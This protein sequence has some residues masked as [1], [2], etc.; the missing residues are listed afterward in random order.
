[1][2]CSSVL[3]S[4]SAALNKYV[5]CHRKFLRARI[6]EVR[7]KSVRDWSQSGAP[8]EFTQHSHSVLKIIVRDLPSLLSTVRGIYSKA[9]RWLCIILKIGVMGINSSV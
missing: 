1:M 6:D 2:C 9:T 4:W 5:D 7:N 8:Q 3:Q